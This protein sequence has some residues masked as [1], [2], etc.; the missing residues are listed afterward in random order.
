[1]EISKG[2]ERKYFNFPTQKDETLHQGVCFFPRETQIEVNFQRKT[3]E[4]NILQS[5]T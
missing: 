5:S 3:L 4:A 2:K 1:M